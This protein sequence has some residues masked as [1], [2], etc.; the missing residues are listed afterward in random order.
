MNIILTLN[1]AVFIFLGSKKEHVFFL[2]FKNMLKVEDHDF[3]TK[4]T[5]C[6]LSGHNLFTMSKILTQIY[7]VL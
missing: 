5:S 6:T 3:I 1:T 4:I 2:S 7:R